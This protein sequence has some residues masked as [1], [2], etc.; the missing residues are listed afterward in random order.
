MQLTLCNISMLAL[1][2]FGHL[3]N[4]GPIVILLL[5]LAWPV[6]TPEGN[7]CFLAA[8]CSAIFTS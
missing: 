1:F 5:T 6:P 8:K 2:V 3:M 7:I 4:V